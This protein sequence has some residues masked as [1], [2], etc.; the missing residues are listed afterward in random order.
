MRTVA[1]TIWFGSFTFFFKHNNCQ[2]WS[3]SRRFFPF[4]C[5]QIS[6]GQCALKM[7]DDEI[8]FCICVFLYY[9]GYLSSRT[10]HSWLM[11][12]AIILTLLFFKVCLSLLSKFKKYISNFESWSLPKFFRAPHFLCSVKEFWKAVTRFTVIQS[13]NL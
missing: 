4:P 12:Y 9:F 10:V 11:F 7:S 1:I 3:K 8:L 5:V 6:E 2:L 13:W